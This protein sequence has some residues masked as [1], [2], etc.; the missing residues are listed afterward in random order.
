MTVPVASCS[1]ATKYTRFNGKESTLEILILCYRICS[2]GIRCVS[3]FYCNFYFLFLFHNIVVLFSH[4]KAYHSCTHSCGMQRSCSCLWMT[5]KK[6]LKFRKVALDVLILRMYSFTLKQKIQFVRM[7]GG[8]CGCR[9]VRSCQTYFWIFHC[10]TFCI[11]ITPSHPEPRSPSQEEK[12]HGNSKLPLFS[13]Q[14]N[15]MRS[16]ELR[17]PYHLFSSPSSRS[18]ILCL[19][20]ITRLFHC[21]VIRVRFVPVKT[22]T[23]PETPIELLVG[24]EARRTRNGRGLCAN[25]NPTVIIT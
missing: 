24:W 11:L 3:R 7:P 20:A 16:L 9:S 8:K 5:A 10:H 13:H 12:S 25:E 1:Y 2:L 6:F 18:P 14:T 19:P 22:V 15:N 4:T 17:Q 21:H 23:Q